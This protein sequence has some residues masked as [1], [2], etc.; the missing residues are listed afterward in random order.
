MNVNFDKF[1]KFLDDR[2]NHYANNIL[3][4]DNK[5]DRSA[6]GELDFYVSLR[7]ALLHAD[8][9]DAFD[10]ESLRSKG[11]FDAMNATLVELGY[12]KKGSHFL[13]I[14]EK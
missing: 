13:D 6:T 7:S 10:R 12:I 2:I 1:L 8:S 3:N 9:R 11:L 5:N 14:I 4:L